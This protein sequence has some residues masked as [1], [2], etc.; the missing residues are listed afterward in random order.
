MHGSDRAESR[1]ECAKNNVS[2][3]FFYYYAGPQ[4]D[5][6][7]ANRLLPGPNHLCATKREVAW[8][9]YGTPPTEQISSLSAPPPHYRVIST[10]PPPSASNCN[11]SASA[12]LSYTSDATVSTTNHRTR[13][14][15]PRGSRTLSK[16]TSHV[17]TVRSH[18]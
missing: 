6:S 15:E 18:V 16:S 8:R 10:L 2:V 1:L 7:V 3:F 17:V 4:S 9:H 14:P 13:T 5:F 11:G 12:R